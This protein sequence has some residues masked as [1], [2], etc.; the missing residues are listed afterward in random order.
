MHKMRKLRPLRLLLR[1]DNARPRV[2]TF[3]FPEEP[4]AEDDTEETC[5]EVE[6]EE[7]V[8]NIGCYAV[9]GECHAQLFS[10]EP[11]QL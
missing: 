6:G 7:Y 10:V 5:E 8:N 11:R 3:G 1:F 4:G 2:Q 9:T